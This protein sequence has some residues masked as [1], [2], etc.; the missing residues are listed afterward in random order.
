MSWIS[1]T[2]DEG[3]DKLVFDET[4]VDIPS[5]NTTFEYYVRKM[6]P[7]YYQTLVYD[8]LFK[9]DAYV[10]LTKTE[11]EDKSK[12]GTVTLNTDTFVRMENEI[13]ELKRKNAEL[14]KDNEELIDSNIAFEEE[15]EKLKGKK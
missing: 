2:D 12:S 5:G 13:E 7:E 6:D 3:V 11:A 4:K 10:T 15:I 1:N 14:E 9:E 8:P